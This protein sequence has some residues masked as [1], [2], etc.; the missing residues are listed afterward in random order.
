MTVT[1]GNDMGP[2][3]EFNGKKSK[4]YMEGKTLNST[5]T[6]EKIA[7]T[8]ID[9]I[10]IYRYY[11]YTDIILLLCENGAFK[12]SEAVQM[13]TGSREGMEFICSKQYI[14]RIRNYFHIARKL[15]FQE[16]V[17]QRF[18]R[19]IAALERQSVFNDEYRDNTY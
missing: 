9:I 19:A 4:F 16:S 17:K 1:Y 18:E 15:E 10:Y 11:I 6:V 5:L 3:D 7:V 13:L 8:T 14:E 2:W 12:E